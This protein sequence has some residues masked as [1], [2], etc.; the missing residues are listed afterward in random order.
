M[1]YNVHFTLILPAY[2]NL[3]SSFITDHVA[4]TTLTKSPNVP[5]LRYEHNP[6]NPFALLKDFFFW[7]RITILFAHFGS[8]ICRCCCYWFCSRLLSQFRLWRTASSL[9]FRTFYG[10]SCDQGLKVHRIGTYL[11]IGN[12]SG[13]LK[14]K[15]GNQEK[16]LVFLV[17]MF[18]YLLFS[19]YHIIYLTSSGQST[20]MSQGARLKC[21]IA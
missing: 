11:H 9:H 15:R 17:E 20:Y 4:E 10:L 6:H 16:L 13:T 3:V 1:F 19:I 18:I 14:K 12:P 7:K 2:T 5:T 21:N 8:T